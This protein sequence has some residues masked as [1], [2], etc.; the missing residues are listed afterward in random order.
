LK[1]GVG[2]AI[3]NVLAICQECGKPYESMV[4]V[5]AKK[6]GFFPQGFCRCKA[7]KKMRVRTHMS[8][9]GVKS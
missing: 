5:W 2:D 9:S 4:P 6:S 1:A 7:V 3:L 8:K